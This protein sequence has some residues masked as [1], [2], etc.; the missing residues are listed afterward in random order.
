MPNSPEIGAHNHQLQ[1]QHP[2]L[3]PLHIS[4]LI[5]P[6]LLPPFPYRRVLSITLIVATYISTT[7]T[8][9]SPDP[10]ISYAVAS[11]W[12]FSLRVL[13]IHLFSSPNPEAVLYRVGS[14]GKEGEAKKTRARKDVANTYG[15][16]LKKLCWIG[17]LLFSLRGL[18]W[19]YQIPAVNPSV[20]P[21]THL[22]WKSYA[23]Y[24]FRRLVTIYLLIDVA[25][26]FCYINPSRYVLESGTSSPLP[27]VLATILAALSNG[28]I[29]W[30]FI[31]LQYLLLSVPCIW[32]LG[33]HPSQWPPLFGSV[34]DCYR[35]GYLWGR[36]W[37][38]LLRAT[39]LPW[40]DFLCTTLNI[41]S[42][43]ARQVVRVLVAFTLSGLG[44]SNVVY[45]V[46]RGK[47]GRESI[48]F[49][50]LQALGILIEIAVL[51]GWRWLR[52][53]A[54]EDW[55][56]RWGKYLGYAWVLGW[57]SWTSMFQIQDMRRLGFGEPMP[58]SLLRWGLGWPQK[59]K[60]G[61]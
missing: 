48:L 51:N 33:Q 44:H 46:S 24:L 4:T 41:R 32:I 55:Q 39:L 36:G 14:V 8:P 38:Q 5:I 13:T 47:F 6:L 52:P 49:F 21:S 31:E 60:E 11:L 25:R 40:G 37:H 20:L 45:V 61:C 15:V 29:S 30:G 12:V 26:T 17:S 19:S 28:T 34:E 16:G 27:G 35:V 10:G 42:K 1:L 56:K 22:T 7:I 59:C 57:L 54:P 2:L 3:L 23:I 9:F 43:N 18:N 58:W 53:G 50:F